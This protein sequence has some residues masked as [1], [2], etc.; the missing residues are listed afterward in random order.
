M[1]FAQTRGSIEQIVAYIL[2]VREIYHVISYY[3]SAHIE[4]FTLS[5]VFYG[6]AQSNAL[7]TQQISV[8]VCCGSVEARGHYLLVLAGRDGVPHP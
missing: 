5:T 3:S 2:V 7:A 1:K 8:E 4:P 6:N